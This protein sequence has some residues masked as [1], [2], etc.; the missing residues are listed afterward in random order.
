MSPSSRYAAWRPFARD[1]FSHAVAGTVGAA[2]A[3]AGVHFGWFR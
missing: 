3:L 1:F 2:V